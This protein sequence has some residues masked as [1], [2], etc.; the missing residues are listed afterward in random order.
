[1]AGLQSPCYDCLKVPGSVFY[2]L[3]DE[4]KEQLIRGNSI[5]SFVKG[6]L[7]YREGERPNGIICLSSGKVKIIKEGVS[8]REQI[9]R[10]VRPSGILGYR[11]LFADEMY[12]A[13]AITLEDSIVC[14][15]HRDDILDL[16]R[17]QPEFALRILKAMA[18]ELGLSNA[19]TVNLTQKHIRGRLAESLLFLSNTYGFE[20]DGMTIRA[21]LSR[22][23]LANLSNM[24]ASN[25]IRTLS[26]FYQEGLVDIEGRRIKVLKPNELERVSRMG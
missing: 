14:Q 11:A 20:G 19:R 1:M 4:D 18:Y 3:S 26:N 7:I 24:T 13:T 9:I 12:Q 23:D 5:R 15:F 2:N 17:H 25:A 8:G 6:E 22:E 16:I 21:Y 10:L